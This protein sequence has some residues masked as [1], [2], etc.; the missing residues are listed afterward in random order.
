MSR[1]GPKVTVIRN[2]TG[3]A[4][5]SVARYSVEDGNSDDSGYDHECKG[6]GESRYIGES[7]KTPEWCPVAPPTAEPV[8]SGEGEALRLLREAIEQLQ[9]LEAVNFD[10]TDLRDSVNLRARIEALLAKVDGGGK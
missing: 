2:C 3:C 7:D 4:H 8:A 9:N 5:H 6:G 10:E 1:I